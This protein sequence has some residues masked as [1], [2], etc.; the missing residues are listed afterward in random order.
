M[1]AFENTKV[2]QL[3]HLRDRQV[4]TTEFRKLCLETF[5]D[6]VETSSQ[7]SIVIRDS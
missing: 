4:K 2:R 1:I 5:L 6:S 7:R 3:K